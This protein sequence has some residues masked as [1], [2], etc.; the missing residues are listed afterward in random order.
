L[1]DQ[2]ITRPLVL[3]HFAPSGPAQGKLLDDQ[4]KATSLPE[5]MLAG[6]TDYAVPPLS[7]TRLTI[8]GQVTH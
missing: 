4:H 5:I 6:K 3:D 8:P 7:I 1:N 2:A